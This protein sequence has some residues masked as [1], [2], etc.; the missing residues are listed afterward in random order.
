MIRVRQR[1]DRWQRLGPLK[2][3]AS[4]RDVP[5]GPI[6]INALKEWR[7]ACPKNELDL[8]FPT[9]AG[10]VESLANIYNRGLAPLQVRAGIVSG[11]KLDRHGK[12]ALDKQGKPIMLPK[13]GL[14]ALRHFFASWLIDQGF[15]QSAS[16][17]SWGTAAF[18]SPSTPT[19][20]CSRRKTITSAL[21]PA[22]WR[23]LADDCDKV[24]K[25]RAL[26]R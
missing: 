11:P 20:T 14:H 21:R 3:A 4:R 10:N 23:S 25:N 22:S 1:A 26:A 5:M 12:P 8:V 19:D 15:G 17:R 16:R 7:L 18:R 24:A 13:Y 2:S 6:V 9:G